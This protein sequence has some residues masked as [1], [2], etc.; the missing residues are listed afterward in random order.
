MAS[1]RSFAQHSRINFGD[2]PDL[3]IPSPFQSCSSAYESPTSPG[4]S[5]PSRPAT[6]ATPF[7]PGSF[8]GGEFAFIDISTQ[9]SD[10]VSGTPKPCHW[11]RY[12]KKKTGT[13]KKGQKRP[14]RTSNVSESPSKKRDYIERPVT[15]MFSEIHFPTPLSRNLSK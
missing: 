11:K 12:R 4:L 3:V 7:S 10:G 1:S 13:Y 6:P 2:L 9:T 15:P 8:L 5:V 14:P